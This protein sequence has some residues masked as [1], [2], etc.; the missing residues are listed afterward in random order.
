MIAI[1]CA[2]GFEMFHSSEGGAREGR[3][4]GEGGAR[5]THSY[6]IYIRGFNVVSCS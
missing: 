3:G 2:C 1:D 5:E 6:V 4:R